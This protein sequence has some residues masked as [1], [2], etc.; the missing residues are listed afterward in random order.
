MSAS[1]KPIDKTIINKKRMYFGA[2]EVIKNI[3][4]GSKDFNILKLYI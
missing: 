1:I 2:L 4:F 3:L